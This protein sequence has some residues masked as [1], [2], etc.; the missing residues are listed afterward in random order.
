[1][2]SNRGAQSRVEQRITLSR[3]LITHVQSPRHNSNGI[4]ICKHRNLEVPKK[5]FPRP[6]QPVLGPSSPVELLNGN[7]FGGRA[8]CQGVCKNMFKDTTLILG[9]KQ[10]REFKSEVSLLLKSLRGPQEFKNYPG[11]IFFIKALA[12]PCPPYHLPNMVCFHPKRVCFFYKS[13]YI[14]DKMSKLWRLVEVA[15]SSL[16]SPS[17]C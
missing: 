15:A 13:N 11:S 5:T 7:A 1:M 17:A 14:Q 8:T 4:N 9:A 3:S 2:T 16:N 12:I 10:D 6:D